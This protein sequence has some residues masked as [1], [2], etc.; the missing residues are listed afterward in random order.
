[1]TG[2][3]NAQLY[4]TVADACDPAA[5]VVCHKDRVSGLWNGKTAFSD[6]LKEHGIHTLLFAGVNTNQCVHGTFLDAYYRGYD[7]IL[8]E[9]CCATKTPGGQEVPVIDV[10]VSEVTGQFFPRKRI[11]RQDPGVEQGCNILTISQRAFGF[12]VNS[13]SLCAKGP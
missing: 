7:C 5:D 3:W 2:S 10:S 6:A 4:K 11:P 13:G 1:M 9:D 8:V 12:V